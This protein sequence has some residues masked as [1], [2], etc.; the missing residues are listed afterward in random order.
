MVEIALVV[1][2]I[3]AYFV[4]LCVGYV[5]GKGSVWVELVEMRRRIDWE[6]T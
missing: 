1:L 3:L 5:A 2:V 6:V 4:G